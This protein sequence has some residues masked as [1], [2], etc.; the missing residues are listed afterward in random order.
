MI[1]VSNYCVSNYC[2]HDYSEVSLER[3]NIAQGVHH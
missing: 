2:A 3:Q 1:I